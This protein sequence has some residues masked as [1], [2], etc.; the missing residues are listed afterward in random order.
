LKANRWV[1]M[2]RILKLTL[3]WQQPQ[4]NCGSHR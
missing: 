3:Q 4:Q 1:N 2:R